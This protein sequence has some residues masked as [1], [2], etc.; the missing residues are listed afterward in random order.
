MNCNIYTVCDTFTDKYDL[1]KKK[2]WFVNFFIQE[3]LF[4]NLISAI[5]YISD[6][7]A[8]MISLYPATSGAWLLTPIHLLE[9]YRLIGHGGDLSGYHSYLSMLPDMGVGFFFT[10]NDGRH[11]RERLYA[12]TFL[13]DIL[14]GEEPWLDAEMVCDMLNAT[15]PRETY[16]LPDVKE[17]LGVFN[18][19]SLMLY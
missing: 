16:D 8:V 4:I 5:A 13:Y 1:T 19:K 9:G 15:D 7:C 11:T 3:F 2:F 14:L 18:F 10:C 6:L 17:L 12:T